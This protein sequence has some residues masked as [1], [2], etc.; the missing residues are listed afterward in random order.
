MNE[1]NTKYLWNC[2]QKAGDYLSGQLPSHPNH[3]KGR[4]P[5]AHVAICIKSKFN[6]S[7]K[8]I[9]DIMFEEVLNYIE[10]L[11]NNPQ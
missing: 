6:N 11:K 9:D 3:P 7:Y 8:D 2:I 5:Y 4:N 1:E 10:F